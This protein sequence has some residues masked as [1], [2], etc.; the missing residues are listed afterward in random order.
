MSGRKKMNSILQ[1]S[2]THQCYL[3]SI[4]GRFPFKD[5]LHKHHI[6]NGPNR[7]ISEANGFVCKLC[8]DCHERVHVDIKARNIL[9]EICQRE[10][11]KTHSR[12]EFM[13]L[14]GK[15]YLD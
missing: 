2:D 8:P 15:N 1:R 4:E 10:Y 13:D 12:E 11:E 14:I 5:W 3:C 9:K 6:F 7:P